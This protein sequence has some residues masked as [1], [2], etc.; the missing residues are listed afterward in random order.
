M[1]YF[2]VVVICIS[3]MINEGFPAGS[4]DKE[5]ACNVVDLGSIPGLGRFPGE[6]NDNLL[7]YSCL[8]I[9]MGRGAWQATVHRVNM[10]EVTEDI[11]FLHFCIY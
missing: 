5:S 1:C 9:P 7:Q 4:D 10:T 6:G 2:I 11:H 3:L 8:G